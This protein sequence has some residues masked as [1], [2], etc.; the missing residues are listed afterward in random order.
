ME[1]TDFCFLGHAVLGPRI[2]SKI[3][4]KGVLNPTH[5]QGN[6]VNRVYY[7]GKMV[8]GYQIMEEGKDAAFGKHILGSRYVVTVDGFQG[9][10]KQL[11]EVFLPEKKPRK[12][13]SNDKQQKIID[14]VKAGIPS[15]EIAQQL[16]MKPASLHSKVYQLRKKG[17]LPKVEEMKIEAMAKKVHEKVEEP[18]EVGKISTVQNVMTIELGTRVKSAITLAAAMLVMGVEF[19][20]D[21]LAERAVNITDKILERIGK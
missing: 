5:I 14:M 10:L 6:D 18:T 12:R 13:I 9:F 3:V 20:D 8:H 1:I 21:Q 19:T 11:A 4:Q 7:V 16:N 17:L 15:S 2:I